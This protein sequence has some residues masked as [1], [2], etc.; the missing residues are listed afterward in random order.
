[1]RF[2]TGVVLRWNEKGFGFIK[3]DDGGEDLFC[4]FSSI[5]DGNA[6]EK[7]SWVQFVKV[8]DERKGKDRAEKV[9]GGIQEEDLG[10]G[11]GIYGKVENADASGGGGGGGG[12]GS[13][14]GPDN[15]K[16]SDYGADGHRWRW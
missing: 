1:V 4:H 15:P 12:G 16:L 7:D 6:L 11:A 2:T 14:R 5:E 3:P 10:R 13:S 9:T 8:Y